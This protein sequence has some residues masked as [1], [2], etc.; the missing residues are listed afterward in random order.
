LIGHDIHR[1]SID[2]QDP[3]RI[4]AG[5]GEGLFISTDAG[6]NWTLVIGM[7]N[8]YVHGIFS[9]LMNLLE[10]LFMFLSLK[11]LYILAMTEV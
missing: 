2:P 4:F 9:I 8:K 10:Y 1:I 7:E 6:R 11:I 5:T 3:D